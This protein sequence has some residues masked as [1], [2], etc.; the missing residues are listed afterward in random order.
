M[1]TVESTGVCLSHLLITNDTIILVVVICLRRYRG[2]GHCYR[3][4]AWLLKRW[5]EG[6]EEIITVRSLNEWA[7]DH[8]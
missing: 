8:Y 6:E 3:R 5:W 7:S 4:K 1:A 2:R